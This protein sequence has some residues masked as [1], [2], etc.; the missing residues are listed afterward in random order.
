VRVFTIDGRAVKSF[1]DFIA[2]M[3][4]GFVRHVGGDWNGNLD[5][6][7]DYLSWPD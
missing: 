3:N 4:T 5:A 6:L 1:D 7:N 2:A